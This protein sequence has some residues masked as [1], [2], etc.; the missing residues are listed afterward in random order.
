ML[1]K[2]SIVLS[3]GAASYADQNTDLTDNQILLLRTG[4]ISAGEGGKWYVNSQDGKVQNFMVGF[5]AVPG[6]ASDNFFG[7][8]FAQTLA[9]GVSAFSAIFTLAI[10]SGKSSAKSE[11]TAIVSKFVAQVIVAGTV[12]HLMGAAQ[13]IISSIG[14][15]IMDVLSPLVGVA[16]EVNEG[17]L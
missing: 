16:N 11:A 3:E 15:S 6:Y 17:E 12:I 9:F 2:S 4:L 13:S 1:D 8:Y 14:Q 5:L 10:S 7:P